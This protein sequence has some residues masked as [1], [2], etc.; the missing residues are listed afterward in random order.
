MLKRGIVELLAGVGVARLA[1]PRPDDA[2][3]GDRQAFDL[4]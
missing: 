2:K 3:G 4:L 1:V